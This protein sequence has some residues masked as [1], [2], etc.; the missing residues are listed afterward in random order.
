MTNLNSRLTQLEKRANEQPYN[1]PQIVEIWG[2]R[3]DGTT[4]LIDTWRGL[5]EAETLSNSD[6]SPLD[7]EYNR[8]MTTLAEALK[9]IESNEQS[10]QQ[11]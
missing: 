5:M 11:S 2:T 4:Y 9:E 1:P 3:E 7:T 10:K 8:S 6:G